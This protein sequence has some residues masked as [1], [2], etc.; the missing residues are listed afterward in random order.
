MRDRTPDT[1]SG[2]DGAIVPDDKRAV[3]QVGIEKPNEGR[4]ETEIDKFVQ[5]TIPPGFVKRLGEVKKDNTSA[6]VGIE[7][8]MNELDDTE[9]LECRR[10]SRAKAE[11]L[12]DDDVVLPQKLIQPKED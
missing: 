9:E 6:P 8:I 3:R 12:G 11:L 4:G 1:P 10:V 7:T 5:K 2:G